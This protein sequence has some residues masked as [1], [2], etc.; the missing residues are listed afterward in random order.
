MCVFWI[1]S[2]AKFSPRSHLLTWYTHNHLHI[3]TSC[4]FS[5][6]RFSPQSDVK[7]SQTEDY[8]RN[9]LNCKLFGDFGLIQKARRIR[10]EE[11]KHI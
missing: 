6:D 11:L 9:L 4:T 5:E 3:R 8:I 1:I 7:L 2:H 10:D